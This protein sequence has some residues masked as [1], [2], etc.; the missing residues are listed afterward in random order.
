KLTVLTISRPF[1]AASLNPWIVGGAD[2]SPGSWPW[3]AYLSIAGSDGSYMCGGALINK[4]WILTAA[5]CICSIILLDSEGL[6]ERHLTSL[7]VVKRGVAEWRMHP[8][9]DCILGQRLDNDIALIKMS[10]PVTY[11]TYIQPVCLAQ[12]NSTFH[13]GVKAWVA[14][15]GTLEFG[16]T[17]TIL[18]EVSLPVVGDNQCQC[19]YTSLDLSIPGKTICAG[20]PEG[21][22]DSCQGDS[23]GPLVVKKGSNWVQAGVVSFG[24]ECARRNKPGVYTEVSEFRTGSRTPLGLRTLPNSSHTPHQEWTATSLTPAQLLPLLLL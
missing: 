16:T 21:K 23:G 12:K 15:W 9:Y 8:F 1:F 5:H 19:N 4:Q 14:G 7:E 2:A 22:K 10:E 24:Y 18:Q 3:Q 17:P 20:Y 13:T 6:R 11:T